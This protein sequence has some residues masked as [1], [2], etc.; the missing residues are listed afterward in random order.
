MEG[1]C[2]KMMVDLEM[3]TSHQGLESQRL[4][5]MMTRDFEESGRVLRREKQRDTNLSTRSGPASGPTIK[6]DRLG[7]CSIYLGLWL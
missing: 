6:L 7:A 4:N 3:I 1:S 2:Y 5:G